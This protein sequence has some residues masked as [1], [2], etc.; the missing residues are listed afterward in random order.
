MMTKTIE[1]HLEMKIKCMFA[2]NV[3]LQFDVGPA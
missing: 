2:G 3:Y 1:I